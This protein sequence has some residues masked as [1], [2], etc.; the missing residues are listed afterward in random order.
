MKTPLDPITVA[1]MLFV[2]ATV[3]KLDSNAGTLAGRQFQNQLREQTDWWL[4]GE[5]PLTESQITE[6]RTIV[7]QMCAVVEAYFDGMAPLDAF[8]DLMDSDNKTG[9][10]GDG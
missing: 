1:L 9:G 4:D 5:T 3:V 7:A 10:R 6:V 2:A 8:D